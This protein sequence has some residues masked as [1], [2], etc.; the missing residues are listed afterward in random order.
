MI[1]RS[2]VFDFDGTLADT[3]GELRRIFNEIAPD[4][5]LR[6]IAEYEVPALRQ[7]SLSEVLNEL[8]I[9]KHRVPSLLNRGTKMLRSSITNIPPIDGI[10]EILAALRPRVEKLGI[11]TSNTDENV[12]LFL[13]SHQLEGIFDF[14]SCKSKLSGKAKHLQA[15]LTTFSLKAHEVLYIGDELRDVKACQKVGIPVAAVTWGFNAR[16]ALAAAA[17]DYLFD[18][19]NDFMQLLDEP[20]A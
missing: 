1:Y 15:I 12:S 8:G 3:F 11:L 19:P 18:Q 2:L 13:K 16:E 4:Y 6:Q 17:P 20:S 10:R 14:I 7:L 5:G 9:P